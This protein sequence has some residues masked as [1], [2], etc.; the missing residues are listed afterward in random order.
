MDRSQ[1][2][3]LAMVMGVRNFLLE[4]EGWGW[5]GDHAGVGQH[6]IKADGDVHDLLGG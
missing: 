6:H 3:G 1:Q 2:V 4:I 5:S